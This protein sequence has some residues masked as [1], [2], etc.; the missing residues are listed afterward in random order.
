MMMKHNVQPKLSAYEQEHQLNAQIEA[1]WDERSRDFSKLRQKELSGP[2]AAAW[3]AY[4]QEKL[5]AAAPLK[6][7]DIGTGAGFFA[8]LLAQL[9]HKVTGIDIK[10]FWLPAVQQNF[11]R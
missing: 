7:L 10:M 8:I 2:C 3:Q 11:A 6:I 4:L 9:G 5:P 1:Y